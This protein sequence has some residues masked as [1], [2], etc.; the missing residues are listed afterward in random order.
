M[1]FR[2]IITM[3]SY[4]FFHVFTFEG[5]LRLATIHMLESIF[6]SATKIRNS[7]DEIVKLHTIILTDSSRLK[8]LQTKVIFFYQSKPTKNISS[9]RFDALTYIT[10]NLSLIHI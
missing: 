2:D 7:D 4:I 8:I 6:N 10:L 3:G 1:A 9:D 5:S